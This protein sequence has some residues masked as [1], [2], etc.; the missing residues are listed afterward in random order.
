MDL[1]PLGAGQSGAGG[2]RAGGDGR[3]GGATSD[4]GDS[5][6]GVG[7]GVGGGGGGCGGGAPRRIDKP[8]LSTKTNNS[9]I[10]EN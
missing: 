7:V 9:L 2:S 5:I 4:C 6:G 10:M 1:G 8:Q 3:G